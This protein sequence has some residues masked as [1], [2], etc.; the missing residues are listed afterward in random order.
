MALMSA[1]IQPIGL[2]W[3]R[4]LTVAD[5]ETMPNDGRR[6]ELIDGVLIVSPAPLIR[7]QLASVRLEAVLGAACPPELL[8]LHAPTDVVLADD[9]SVQPDI[10]VAPWSDFTEKNLPGPPLLAVEILSPSN[11]KYDPE[12]KRDRYQRAGVRSYWMVDPLV[13]R[14]IALELQDGEYV[15]IADISG[16]QSWT[17]VHPFEVTIIPNELVAKP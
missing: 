4:P 11:P 2:P 17:A 10:L 13:P 5:L 6:Y 15:E 8:M 3:G 12:V 7:H 16:D 14:L 9:T 1:Q